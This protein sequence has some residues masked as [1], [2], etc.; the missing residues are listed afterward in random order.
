MRFSPSTRDAGH[1]QKNKILKSSQGHG[2]QEANLDPDVR[3]Y[4]LMLQNS[5]DEPGLTRK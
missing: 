5:E 3:S 4:R 1:K 2:P